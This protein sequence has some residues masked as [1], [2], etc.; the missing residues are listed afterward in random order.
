M[1]ATRGAAAVTTA[2]VLALAPAAAASAATAG[3]VAHPPVPRVKAESATKSAAQK[4]A[5]KKAKAKAAAAGHGMLVICNHTGYV[6][7]VYADGPDAREDDLAGSFDECT[8]WSP[9]STGRYDVGFSMRT[10]SQQPVAIAARFNR[11]GVTYYKTF[12]N[13]GVVGA[14]VGP[15][16]STRID[17][18]VPRA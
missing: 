2:A 7:D 15:D 4:K 16:K 9:V 1:R 11:D 8:D 14:Y 12:N 17:L 6:F 13:Q 5:A 10:P 3:D 18:F